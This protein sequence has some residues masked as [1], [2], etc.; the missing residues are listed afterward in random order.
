[1]LLQSFKENAFRT[2]Q[3][4]VR[5]DVTATRR[6]RRRLRALPWSWDSD[7]GRSVGGASNKITRLQ[8]ALAVLGEDDETDRNAL[9]VALKK[10]Q[11]QAVVPQVSEQIEH[12]QKSSSARRNG[13]C[14]QRSTVSGH[15]TGR[16]SATRSCWRQKNVLRDCA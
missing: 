13:W 5:V 15:K 11:A 6:R 10:G 7:S 2:A 4:S 1:M 12:T 3:D 9:E 14:L 16:S 8:S